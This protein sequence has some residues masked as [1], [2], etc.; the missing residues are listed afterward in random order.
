[1]KRGK[2][3]QLDKLFSKYAEE[4]KQPDRRVQTAAKQALKQEQTVAEFETSPVT[5]GTGGAAHGIF[6][7]KRNIVGA[8][9]ALCIIA[10]AILI[11]LI[12]QFSFSQRSIRLDWTQLNKVSAAG[13]YS[14][15]EFAPFVSEESVNAYDEYELSDDS[16]YY[17]D[18]EG[19]IILYYL[20]YE[21]YGTVIELYIEIDGFELDALEGYLDIENDYE[22]DELLLYI[23]TD[24]IYERTYVYFEYDF[25][26]YY[27][28][29][30]TVDFELLYSILEEIVYSF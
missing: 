25:Y 8:A 12:V 7:R 26:R 6:S 3:E 21:S 18:Y 1:M 17:E 11:Y 27:F 14:E 4:G 28:E 24:D 2:D 13:A 22:A 16:L 15:K 20:Q 9:V 5:A 10:A 19:D 29:I 23:E 30:H